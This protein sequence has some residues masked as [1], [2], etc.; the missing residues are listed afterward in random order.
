M[1]K[2]SF[3]KAKA[4]VKVLPSTLILNLSLN[5]DL[6]VLILTP[7]SLYVRISCREKRAAMQSIKK[8]ILK[9]LPLSIF[10]IAM[11]H[12]EGVVVVYLRGILPT[13][14]KL[15]GV[16]TYTEY[17]RV[18]MSSPIIF[19]EQTRELATIIMLIIFAGLIG[20]NI[21]QRLAVFLYT[22][23]IWDIT[24]YISLYILLRWPPSLSTIDTLF[25]IPGPWVAPVYVPVIASLLM[26]GVGT[27]MLKC[28]VI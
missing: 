16:T 17:A 4:K 27:Y 13:V 21:M 25:L 3:K 5:L 23:G 19:I 10:A 24:Y 28:E 11:G 9:L 15:E 7:F 8:L 12:L 18:L 26:I 20:R 22:F 6:N 14:I 2:I 1:S